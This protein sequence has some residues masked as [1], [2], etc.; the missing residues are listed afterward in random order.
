MPKIPIDIVGS[1]YESRTTAISN[2]VTRN[3]YPEINPKGRSP[4]ALQTFPGNKLKTQGGAGDRCRGLYNW[5]GVLYKVSGNS[6]D[7]IDADGVFTNLGSIAGSGRVVFDS[8]NSTL[9]IISS[10]YKYTYDGTTLSSFTDSAG[11][12]GSPD[13]VAQIKNV[14]VYDDGGNND[15]WVRSVAGDATTSLAD[16]SAE[17]RDDNLIR[18]YVFR[19]VLYL[20][21]SK[22]IEPWFF[23]GTGDLGFSLAEQGI[24]QIG[25]V[26]KY[27]VANTPEFV[28]FVGTDN[29]VYRMVQYQIQN[30][31]SVGIANFLENNTVSDA[32]GYTMTL[33][34]QHIYMLILPTANKVLCYSE[35]NQSWFELSSGVSGDRSRINSYAYCYGKHWVGD[36]DNGSLYELDLDT[37]T[38]NGNAYRRERITAP[39][40]AESAGQAGLSMCCK[41]LEV[42]MRTGVGQITGAVNPSMVFQYSIDDGNSWSS[43]H[44][45]KLGR[46][47]EIQKVRFDHMIT[48][49][50][51][52]YKM[53]VTDNCD[54]SIHSA[55]LDVEFVEW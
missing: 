52:R 46:L 25:T 13:T 47:N 29:Q 32:V 6:L 19:N 39:V 53:Y 22:S 55:V 2:Q 51:I 30:I 10:G 44:W 4:I 54:V 1:T 12:I 36:K 42:V 43:E 21:G 35:E 49:R 41:S 24:N 18:P 28:Y 5:K 33:Q 3:L 37:Y 38:D 7:S 50:E 15:N 11:R 34:G 27:S 48:A 9:V 31:T 20:F 16:A 26:A 45:V 40:N 14:F 17:T 23:T 8:N